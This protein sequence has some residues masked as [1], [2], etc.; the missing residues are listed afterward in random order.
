[1]PSPIGPLTC[2][3]AIE[4]TGTCIALLQTATE[5]IAAV[6]RSR[7]VVKVQDDQLTNQSAQVCS[8][9]TLHRRQFVHYKT[10]NVTRAVTLPAIKALKH[11]IK[12]LVIYYY[13]LVVSKYLEAVDWCA[14]ENAGR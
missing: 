13:F 8:A 11:I 12:R 6:T 2:D 4:D 10:S 3:T 1:V 9:K 7:L 5:L 14:E